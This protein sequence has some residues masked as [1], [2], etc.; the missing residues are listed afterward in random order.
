MK[1]IILL[2]A[3]FLSISAIS[4][5]Q[6]TFSV[7]ADTAYYN[8]PDDGVGY[9]AK[10]SLTSAYSAPVD[11][12]W[13][14][15]KFFIPDPANWSSNGLCDWV[16]CIPFENAGGWTTSSMPASSTQDIFVDMKR[17]AGGATG[18]SQIE[19]EIQEVNGPANR[20]VV[21][22]HTSETDKAMCN[23]LWPTATSNTIKEL[24]KVYPNPA[25]NFI[26]LDIVDKNVSTVQLSNIIGK[27]IQ[28]ISVSNSNNGTYQMSLQAL[29]KG[30]YILQF[31]NEFGKIVGVKRITKK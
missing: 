30:I 4:E 16:T 28:R 26:N 20:K 10:L 7:T 21:I 9:K 13:R 3:A 2:I 11:I 22:V 8:L 12:R 31:K 23:R 27:Q 25:N 5:A 24:V 29:P 1:K 14:V 18:C 17:K 6:I 19:V 15:T